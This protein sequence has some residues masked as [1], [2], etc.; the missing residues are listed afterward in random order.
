MAY[1]TDGIT[2]TE[3]SCIEDKGT[4]MAHAKNMTGKIY[5]DVFRNAVVEKK[6]QS[7][8]QRPTPKT[9]AIQDTT[10]A[11]FLFNKIFRD[12]LDMDKVSK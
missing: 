1:Y 3:L 6:E 7:I 8:T 4:Y 5:F 12:G 11:L 10:K 2:D 9:E